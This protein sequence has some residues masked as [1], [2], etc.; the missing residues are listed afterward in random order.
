MSNP[1]TLDAIS[2][3]E[4][5]DSD[6]GLAREKLGQLDG[7][8]DKI[9]DLKDYHDKKVD[10]DRSVEALR[11]I[12]IS[13]NRLDSESTLLKEK[14]K[15]TLLKI[16]QLEEKIQKYNDSETDIEYNNK[17]ENDIDKLKN[18]IDDL[19]YQIDTIDSKIQTAHAEIQVN[20]T[21]KKTILDTMNEVQDLE[22]KYE[23][24]KYYMDAIKRDGV[25]Y[26]L[27]EKALPT[28][29]GEVN[30]ILSQ[31]VDFGIVLEMDGKNINT[32]LTYD[33]DNIWPL[34]LSSG[35]ERFISSLAIRVGLI[36]VCNLPRPNFLAI[37]EGFG[38]M[39]SDNLN[40]VY[41]LFQYL[42]SQFQFCFIVSHIESMRDTVD[43]LLEI[44][45]EKGFS[46]I[47]FD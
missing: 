3:K 34:E 20:E 33:E 22:T 14:K 18:K 17:V 25:P 19:E 7:I 40:S 9:S 23:A 37:D 44:K 32:Y 46:Q 1:F 30:D 11:D 43:S 26:E 45:K 35:M 13:Q 47:N 42:K 15:T 4:S 28:I 6:K 29:E 8:D 27:I 2:T 24:Y 10:Y 21:K 38:N 5:L 31:M 12:E 39:D 41:M 36:N 16:K